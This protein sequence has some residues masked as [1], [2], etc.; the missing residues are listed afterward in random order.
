MKAL[1]ILSVI[2]ITALAIF[3]SLQNGLA[4]RGRASQSIDSVSKWEKRVLRVLDHVPEDITVFGYVADWNI[5]DSGFI[6]I[7]QDQ[8]YVL[9]QY[10]L[11]P[12][13]VE[14]GLEHEWIIGNFIFPGF[15]DWLDQKLPSYELIE[16]GF[17]IYLIHRTAL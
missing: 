4:A 1:R 11:A 8:E 10:A 15:K 13:M 14:L 9:T 3:T 17:G 2:G 5:P 12:R 6:A 16:I 7:D